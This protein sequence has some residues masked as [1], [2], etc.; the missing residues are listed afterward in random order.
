MIHIAV[1]GA[2]GRG[3]AIVSNL[4][5]AAEG[6]VAIAAVYDP[7]PEVCRTAL[8]EWESPDTAICTSYE[9]AIAFEGV[10]WVIVA[11]P[12]AMHRQQVLAAFAAGKHVFCEKPLATTIDDCQAMHDAHQRSGL[13]FATGFVL[14]Y[15]PIYRKLKELLSAGTI[16]NLLSID[17]N[18]NIRPD[19]GAFIMSNWRRHSNISGPHIL[20]K[21]V[22]DLDL[23]N[24]FIDA[25]PRRVAAFGGRDFFV[26]ANRHLEPYADGTRFRPKADPHRI[27]TA[28]TDDSDLMDNLVSILEYRNNVRVQFQATM[29]NAIP[30]RR[31]YMS[32]TE[33]TLVAELYSSTLRYRRLQDSE[34][35]TV[36]FKADGH[37]G[38]DDFIM[39]ELYATMTTGTPPQ[40]SGEEG[41]DSAVVALAIDQAAREG[42]VV[43]LESIWQRLKR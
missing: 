16:G 11:S 39:R 24:W 17:A 3:R 41:L 37:G 4:L 33:G 2:G 28:F 29:S 8:S 42:Q 6:G 18:E 13:T 22:H 31:L 21:C 43:D 36:D 25:L 10:S 23:L 38:G 9:E 30:E 40:C 26:P 19:H 1:I 7:D 5:K 27:E 34:E 35:T 14:R 12:N 20:E 15:A 32:G